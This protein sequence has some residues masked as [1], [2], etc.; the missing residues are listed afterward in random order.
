MSADI[1]DS[2]TRG[3]E[4]RQA[5]SADA[6]ALSRFFAVSFTHTFGAQNNQDDLAAYLAEAFGEE[7]QRREIA[8]RSTQFWL[9]HPLDRSPAGASEALSPN[10]HPKGATE[11]HSPDRHPAGASEA[12]ECRDLLGCAQLKLG[13]RSQYVSA[14]RQAE[15][16][17]IYADH[18]WHGRGVGQALLNR[19][20]DAATDWGADVLWLGVWEK[21]PRA[22]AF[23]EKNGFRAVGEQPFQLG[24]DRQRDIVMARDLR[25]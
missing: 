11:A 6:A 15:V 1:V 10:R 8:D 23:Y 9:A 13:S 3:F 20:V 7:Q 18:R 5:T 14:E 19:C 21:N 24:R 17:R 16:G 22:I 25:K 12:S 4:I 2:S